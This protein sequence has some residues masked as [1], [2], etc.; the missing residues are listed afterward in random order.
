[1]QVLKKVAMPACPLLG[2][3]LYDVETVRMDQD[4]YR[5]SMLHL[6]CERASCGSGEASGT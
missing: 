6:P 5:Y 4:D 1:M 2:A 3:P